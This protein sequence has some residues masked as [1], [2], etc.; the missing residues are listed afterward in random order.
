[1]TLTPLGLRE[2]STAKGYI[3]PKIRTKI[4]IMIMKQHKML[5]L[6]KC[7]GT[8]SDRV[9]KNCSRK[10]AKKLISSYLFLR[11]YFRIL[12]F[13]YFL[14]ICIFFPLNARFPQSEMHH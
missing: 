4:K 10:T 5:A 14:F 2:R 9:N 13:Y 3:T 7:K 11:N 8:A 1:M 6:K 12:T